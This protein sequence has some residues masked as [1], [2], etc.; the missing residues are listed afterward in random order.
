MTK[1]FVS[2]PGVIRCADSELVSSSLLL[3]VLSSASCSDM[4]FPFVVSCPS[5]I[6]ASP[7]SVLHCLFITGLLVVGFPQWGSPLPPRSVLLHSC[8][9]N[10]NS[11]GNNRLLASLLL[12]L[13][14]ILPVFELRH[15]QS[16][17]GRGHAP[18]AGFL[19]LRSHRQTPVSLCIPS[20]TVSTITTAAFHWA[21]FHPAPSCC[22]IQ[23]LWCCSRQL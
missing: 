15:T 3:A 5:Q 12:R 16:A 6:T 11:G 19:T 7:L 1:A 2:P 4:S 8:H 13:A 20:L 21:V 9:A 18:G 23:A 14:V 17:G 10:S 22:C